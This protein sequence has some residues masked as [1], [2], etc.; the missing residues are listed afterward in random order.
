MKRRDLIQH[1][2]RCGC[3]FLREGSRHTIY[4][5]PDKRKV[6]AVPR[7]NEVREPLV[8]RICKDL[9]IRFPD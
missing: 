2:Q 7:H 6:S 1:L 5:R 3:A 8:R 9:D 4:Y